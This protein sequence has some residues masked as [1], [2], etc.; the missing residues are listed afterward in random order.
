MDCGH[1][2]CPQCQ[3]AVG[4]LWLERQRAKLLPAD[5]YMITFAL[6]APW[7]ALVYDHQLIIFPFAPPRCPPHPSVTL[8]LG[9]SM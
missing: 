3:H 7:R 2:F 8:S 9:L 6:P 4:E 1:R 5:Y